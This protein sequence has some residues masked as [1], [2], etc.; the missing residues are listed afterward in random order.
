MREVV[1]RVPRAAVEDV[2]D[3]LLLIAPQGVRESPAGRYVEL[4]LRGDALPS[5]TELRRAVGRW[6]HRISEH[7]I[8]DD[9]RERRALDYTPQVIGGRL[10]VR[11]EWAPAAMSDGLIEIVLGESAAFGGGTHPTTQ[12]CLEL[13]LGVPPSGSFADLG[14][15]SG[16]LAI[17]AAR[18]AWNPVRALDL[19]PVS[20]EATRA[21]AER[22]GVAID[23]QEADLLREPPPATDG[24]AAN[25][26]AVLHRALAAGFADPAPQVGLLS[27]F[28]PEDAVEI[29]AAY[30]TRGL[31]QRRRV[32]RHGWTVMLVGR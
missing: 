13:L 7:E 11:P 25:V 18:L 24:F 20:I 14:C 9:W 10:I 29:A 2:L 8:P 19:Q 3:R 32:D 17:L 1:L 26:P 6:S 31:R 28:G 5:L 23:A 16:V 27:G 21:N 30:G 22:N 12:A 15:G 4:K